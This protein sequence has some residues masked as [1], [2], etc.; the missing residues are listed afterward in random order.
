M[1]QRNTIREVYDPETGRF[2]LVR[3]SGEILERIVSRDHHVHINKLATLG[4]GI[5][6][7]R[8]IAA[9]HTSDAIKR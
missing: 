9:S 2:R 4:D 6:Y 5:S 8:A 3:K 7:G 1:I